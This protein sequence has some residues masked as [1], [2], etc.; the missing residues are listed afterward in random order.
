MKVTLSHVTKHFGHEAVIPGLDHVFAPGSRTAV[1]GPNGS[2]KST[3]LQLVAGAL[4]PTG[5]TVVHERAGRVLDPLDVYRHVS[6]AAPYLHLYED[7]VLHEAIRSHGRFK[8]FRAGLSVEDV[9]RMALLDGNLYKPVRNLSSGMYQRLKLTLAILSDTDLLL[10]DEPVSN[11]DGKGAGWFRELLLAH[12]D[13]RTLLVASNRQQ[14]ETFACE[15][16]LGTALY[17]G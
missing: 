6:I 14:E 16:V 7:L 13:Q 12:L 10:L 5:G 11:L 4:M 17:G 15:L 2:G 9:A 1:L 3:L 8:P